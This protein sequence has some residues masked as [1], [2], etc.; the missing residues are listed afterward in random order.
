MLPLFSRHLTYTINTKREL[1]R[2][3]LHYGD[4]ETVKKV[5]LGAIIG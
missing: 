5:D 4:S 3:F 2:D 1:Q